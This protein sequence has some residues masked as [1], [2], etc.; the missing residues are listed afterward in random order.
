MHVQPPSMMYTFSEVET[1]GIYLKMIQVTY[2][3]PTADSIL[4]GEKLKAILI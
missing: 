2:D 4:N 3:K 1:E